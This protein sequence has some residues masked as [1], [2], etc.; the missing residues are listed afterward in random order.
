MT[1]YAV[2]RRRDR[3]GEA[4]GRAASAG[5]SGSPVMAAKPLIASARVPKPGRWA[6]GPNWPKPVTRARTRRGLA[7]DSSSQPRPH[8]SR[9]PGRK[10]SMITSAVAARRRRV[11]RPPGVERSRV[12]VRLLRPSSF[13]HRPTP[14]FDGPWPRDGSGFVRV[15]DLDDLRAEVAEH[16][17]GERAGEE[18]GEV[19]D[20]E[21]GE[22][23]R[24][25]GLRVRLWVTWPG[26]S[27]GWSVR[28]GQGVA[29]RG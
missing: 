13:H 28:A 9:V 1:A 21:A 19:E 18:G 6:Y 12:M 26:G 8:F 2:A 20:A 7:A 5:A 23:R 16:G 10:F 22:G 17:G 15:L 4:E 24:V 29:S 11:S 27:Y 25:R 14:S 3:V